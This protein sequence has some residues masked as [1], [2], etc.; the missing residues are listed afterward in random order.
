MGIV[1]KLKGKDAILDMKEF[2]RLSG[3]LTCIGRFADKDTSKVIQGTIIQYNGKFYANEVPFHSG[4]S[5]SPADESGMV[6]TSVELFEID[7]VPKE[8]KPL[9]DCPIYICIWNTLIDNEGPIASYAFCNDQ[10]EEAKKIVNN[11]EDVDIFREG[12]QIT[13]QDFLES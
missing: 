7:Y 4:V 13:K 2:C 8:C 5:I 11:N 12:V 3:E 10:L 1:F 9:D 6:T